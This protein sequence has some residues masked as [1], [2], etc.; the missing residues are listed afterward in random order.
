MKYFTTVAVLDGDAALVQAR[1]LQ[2]LLLLVVDFVVEVASVVLIDVVGAV[3]GTHWA[4][5][6]LVTERDASRYHQGSEH[7][8]AV[9]YNNT[10]YMMCR[11]HQTHMSW[12]RYNPFRH[13]VRTCQPPVLLRLAQEPLLLRE[14]QEMRPWCTCRTKQ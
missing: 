2:L 13:I 14:A 7:R 9:P 10:S 6:R 4:G 11:Q 12:I 1:V 5:N 8:K 3:P